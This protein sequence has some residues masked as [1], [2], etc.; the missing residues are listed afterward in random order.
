MNKF[1]SFVTGAVLGGLISA[2][3]VLLL[4]PKSGDAVRDEIKHEV[5]TILEE[6]RRAM[7][8]RRRE[9]ES[10]LAEMR[11]DATKPDLRQ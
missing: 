2:A 1:I 10:Q 6:G 8:T 3:T 4:T 7:D 5:D 9:M 11:G